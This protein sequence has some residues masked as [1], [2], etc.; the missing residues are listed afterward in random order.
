[1]HAGRQNVTSLWLNV[2][3]PALAYRELTLPTWSIAALAAWRQKHVG[4][5]SAAGDEEGGAMYARTL[6]PC[7]K[8]DDMT[9]VKLS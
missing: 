6:G 2:P 5:G 1:M 4:V 7:S 9:G 3:A 8:D